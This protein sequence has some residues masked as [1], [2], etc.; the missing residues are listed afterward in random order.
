MTVSCA[1]EVISCD[2]P[3]RGA[4]KTVNKPMSRMITIR[5]KQLSMALDGHYDW[6]VTMKGRRDLV[7]AVLC[8]WPRASGL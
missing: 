4:E 6:M 2:I 7:N 1:I 5:C 3:A 8:R